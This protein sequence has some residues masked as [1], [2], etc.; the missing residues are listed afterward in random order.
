MLRGDLCG[1]RAA[2]RV[3]SFEGKEKM[4]L[5]PKARERRAAVTT[6]I[7]AADRHPF[8]MLDNYVPLG[9]GDVRLYRAIREAIPVLD[10]AVM[11]TIRL[12]GGFSVKCADKGAEKE[13]A[14]FL[15]NV[16]VGRSQK[17][18]DAFVDCYL[19]RKSVV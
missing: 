19:D 9:G 3:K 7:R 5:F 13:L 15:R 16:N 14:A 8:G 4:K 2:F 10:A 1:A 12:T 17:G 6:Q 11:K 18:I